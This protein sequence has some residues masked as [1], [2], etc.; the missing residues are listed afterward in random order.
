M[1]S[2]VACLQ[3]DFSVIFYGKQ[4]VFQLEAIKFSGKRFAAILVFLVFVKVH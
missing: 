1:S 3:L 2:V 4:L